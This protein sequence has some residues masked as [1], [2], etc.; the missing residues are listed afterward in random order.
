MFLG[1][2]KDNLLLAKQDATDEEIWQ[3]LQR[4][5][6]PETFSLRQGVAT[7]LGDRGVLISG[8]EAQRLALARA[9][10][11]DFSVIILDEPTANVDQISGIRLLS[12]LLKAAKE[13]SNR[14]IVLIT[15]DSNL[16]AMADRQ[17]IL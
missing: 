10:L 12:D 1:T 5:G 4:V 9:L 6:L 13:K 17:I 15:H 7:E 14:A 3:V 11:A 8:G 16:S 2:V